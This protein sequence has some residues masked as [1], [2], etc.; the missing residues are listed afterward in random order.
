MSLFGARESE[1]GR[2]AQQV[3]HKTKRGHLP[4]QVPAHAVRFR[5]D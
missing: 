1:P 2:R 5:V 3:G 4:K